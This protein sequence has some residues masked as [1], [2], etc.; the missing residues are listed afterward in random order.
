[1]SGNRDADWRLAEGMRHFGTVAAAPGFVGYT[2]S[3]T[4]DFRLADGSPAIGKGLEHGAD[5]PDFYGKSRGQTDAVDLGA[6]QH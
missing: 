1:M 3:G 2:R 6:C 5:G 4:P